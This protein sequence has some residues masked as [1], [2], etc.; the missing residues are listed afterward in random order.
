MNHKAIAALAAGLL[1]LERPAARRRDDAGVLESQNATDDTSD[2]NS[3]DSGDETTTTTD[4]ESSGDTDATD[5]ST[6]GD[7]GDA[8][9]GEP[10]GTT[11]AQFEAENGNVPIRID[12]INLERNGDLVE[13]AMVMTNE[14]PE[15]AS[16][17]SENDQLYWYAHDLF[18]QGNFQIC[19]RR[20]ADRPGRAEDVSVLDSA[21][22][23]LCTGVSVSGRAALPVPFGRPRRQLWRPARQPRNGRPP[24][25]R[26]PGDHRAR[27][28]AVSG[29][30]SGVLATTLTVLATVVFGA[31]SVGH[32]TPFQQGEG[33]AQLHEHLEFRSRDIGYRWR[34]LRQ[35]RTGGGDR[36]ARPRSPS[37]PTS[38]S[39]STRRC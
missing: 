35:L 27:D 31:A 10:I 39:S 7:D 36:R 28:R 3:G 8:G 9:R 21:D 4:E 29:R 19:P 11:R 23:C 14:S 20:R 12:V 16:E 26:L 30:Q 18:G 1:L 32:A 2:D 22:E 33:E 6:N 38:S 25:A 37:Q 17:V 5:S 13:L 15:A 34:A 24:H